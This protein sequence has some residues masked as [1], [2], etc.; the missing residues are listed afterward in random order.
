MRVRVRR[1][2]VMFVRVSMVML[3]VV[4]VIMILAMNA[5]I[6]R[7]VDVKLCAGDAALGGAGDVEVIA[8]QP[9]FGQPGFQLLRIEAEVKQSAEEHVAADAADQ[10]EV[11]RLHSAGERAYLRWSAS[12]LIWLAA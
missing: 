8:A 4:V 7:E 5:Q 11:K 9:E 6:R 1:L 12:V 10:V 3:V 2:K